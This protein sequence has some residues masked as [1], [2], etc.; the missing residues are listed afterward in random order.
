[1]RCDVVPPQ[2]IIMLTRV[3]ADGSLPRLIVHTIDFATGIVPRLATGAKI[4]T[5]NDARG[6]RAIDITL[7]GKI[8]WI[9]NLANES[10][11]LIPDIEYQRL[12]R[13][14]QV[15]RVGTP[16]SALPRLMFWFWIASQFHWMYLPIFVMD[17]RREEW[18]EYKFAP[19][20]DV[21][22]LIEY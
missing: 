14:S 16:D 10:H 18:Y 9:T 20:L 4:A 22:D 17:H 2:D 15:L 5:G 12:L 11:E 19:L 7:S 13:I 1:M 8:P 6:F 21:R 3:V